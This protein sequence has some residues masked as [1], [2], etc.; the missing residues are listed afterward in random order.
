MCPQFRLKSFD[1]QPQTSR[2]SITALDGY[3]GKAIYGKTHHFLG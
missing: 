2:E 3:R 1:G